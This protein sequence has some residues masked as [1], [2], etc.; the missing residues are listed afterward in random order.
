[1]LF[2]KQLTSTFNQWNDVGY[3]VEAPY[4]YPNLSVKENLKI[5]YTLRQLKDPLLVDLTI[6]KLK[7]SN[8]QNVKAKFLSMANQHLAL[9]IVCTS[10]FLMTLSFSSFDVNSLV[11]R[12]TVDPFTLP[13]LF[14]GNTPIKQNKRSNQ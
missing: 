5:Y 3:L 9:S 11:N 6:G 8:Y 10:T 4:S 14:I 7:L 13:L 1:M 12:K 2:G